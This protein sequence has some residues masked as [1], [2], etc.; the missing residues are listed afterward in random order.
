LHMM[1]RSSFQIRAF[2]AIGQQ[3]ANWA[4]KRYSFSGSEIILR[5]HH[6]IIHQHS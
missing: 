4:T 2:A 3:I 1:S 5:R 6:S